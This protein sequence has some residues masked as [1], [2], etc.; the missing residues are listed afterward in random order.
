[1]QKGRRQRKVVDAG[2]A[3]ADDK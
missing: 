2:Q 1:M 3:E